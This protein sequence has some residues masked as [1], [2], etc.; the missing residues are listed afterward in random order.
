VVFRAVFFNAFEI[1]VTS[2]TAL[3]SC[4]HLLK[5]TQSVLMSAT[6]ATLTA[7][8]TTLQQQRNNINAKNVL[9]PSD[10]R[11]YATKIIE[12]E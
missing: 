11:V 6:K 4:D 10:T 7:A 2:N 3:H 5:T 8:I 9:K 12:K 1:F